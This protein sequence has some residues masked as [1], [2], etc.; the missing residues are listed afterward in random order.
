[1]PRQVK[2]CKMTPEQILLTGWLTKVS[3]SFSVLLCQHQF[4]AIRLSLRSN[5]PLQ[6]QKKFLHRDNQCAL[7]EW[8]QEC[9]K[10]L[11]Y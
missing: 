7:N 11:M 5:A 9:L 3:T 6:N 10:S 8:I 1:M 4:E 2:E